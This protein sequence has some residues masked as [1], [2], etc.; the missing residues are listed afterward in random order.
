MSGKGVV[1][2]IAARNLDLVVTA[3]VKCKVSKCNESGLISHTA[4]FVIVKALMTG[5]IQ[6]ASDVTKDDNI[7]FDMSRESNLLTY[8]DIVEPT[9]V[10][11]AKDEEE[12]KSGFS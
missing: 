8:T 12:V 6:K 10:V 3:L 1:D 5:V 4:N 9:A 11:A 7:D 2:S